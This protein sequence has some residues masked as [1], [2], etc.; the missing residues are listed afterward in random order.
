MRSAAHWPNKPASTYASATVRSTRPASDHSRSAARFLV[1]T[2]F[3]ARR[4]SRRASANAA[5]SLLLESRAAAKASDI[6]A[7]TRKQDGEQTGTTDKARVHQPRQLQTCG[8][9]ATRMRAAP[10][11][12]PRA[13]TQASKQQIDTLESVWLTWCRPMQ[14]LAR[15]LQDWRVH[16][17]SWRFLA[18][19]GG[20]MAVPGEPPACTDRADRRP[21]ADADRTRP[22]SAG[23]V[24]AKYPWTTRKPHAD[25]FGVR[26]RGMSAKPKLGPRTDRTSIHSANRPHRPSTQAARRNTRANRSKR[27]SARA[28]SRPSARN[29]L[30][31]I[32][33]T[34]R[35][36]R[37]RTVRTVGL[38]RAAK[39]SAEARRANAPCG[40]HPQPVSADGALP[41]SA[42]AWRTRARN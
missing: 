33:R 16:C 20:P 8:A 2:Q 28:V 27:C 34:A 17:S 41:R 10:T 31:D 25:P 39:W 35:A 23:T 30:A 13:C 19:L 4:T 42:L 26:A 21:T 38:D 24:P 11:H 29:F 32:A 40:L 7:T 3:R 1:A 37:A 36:D 12:T 5:A 22:L 9:V 6:A 15:C 14:F 18:A